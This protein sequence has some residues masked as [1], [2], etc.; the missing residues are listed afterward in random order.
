M[1]KLYNVKRWGSMGV[2][3][4]LEELGVPYQNVWMTAEQVRVPEF[5]DISPLGLIPALGL[6]DGRTMI[7]SAAMVS[8]LTTAH[9]EKGLAPVPGTADHGIYLS[10]LHFM[11]TN[12]YVS[13]DLTMTEND[14]GFQKLHRELAIIEKHLLEEGPLMLGNTFSALDVYLFMLTIW[15]KPSE[16]K[17][18]DMYPAIARVCAEV[19]ARPKLKAALEAHGT[20]TVGAYGG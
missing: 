10:W 15:C 8:F 14:P 6:A 19:R 9:A 13:I 17:V 20:Y 12:V 3:L 11:S 4:V 18:L 7:E 1:Y 16:Q 5:R 2:H